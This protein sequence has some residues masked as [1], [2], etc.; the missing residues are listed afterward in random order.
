[1]P[2]GL[3]TTGQPPKIFYWLDIHKPLSKDCNGT[4]IGQAT[5][6]KTATTNFFKMQ[7]PVEYLGF[8]LNPDMVEFTKALIFY[9]WSDNIFRP[10]ALGSP[11]TILMLDA[12]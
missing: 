5:C 1:M 4:D 6:G 12:L 2:Q 9:Y 7:K 3:E 11:S 8:L 10:V